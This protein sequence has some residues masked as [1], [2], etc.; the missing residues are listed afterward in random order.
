MCEPSRHNMTS[1]TP[2]RGPGGGLKRKHGV[3]EDVGKTH[4]D[5]LEGFG[6]DLQDGKLAGF[7]REHWEEE[8]ANEKTHGGA[9]VACD[10][11]EHPIP[12]AYC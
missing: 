4:V 5:W 10:E 9:N 3:E 11:D 2:P 8:K 12:S 6:C 7:E 1:S